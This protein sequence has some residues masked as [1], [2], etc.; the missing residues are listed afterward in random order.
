MKKINC[1]SCPIEVGDLEQ[2]SFVDLL[3]NHY[4]SVRKVIIVDENTHDFCLEYLLTAFPTLE[5]AEVILLP[6]GE[7]NKVMEVCF[8]VLEALS[9]YGIVRSDLIITLGGGVVSD[10]GGFIASIYKRG[11]DCIHIPTSLL[12]MVDAS[13]GGKTGIDLGNYKNQIGTFHHPVAVFID[14]RFLSTLPEEEWKSGFA[15]V[16]KHALVSDKEE[17][18]RLI[19][20]KQDELFSEENLALLLEKSVSIKSNV[21]T[22]DPTEKGKRKILNFGHTIGHAIEGYYLDLEP[23]SHGNCVALGIIAEAYLSNK[24]GTLSTEDLHGIVQVIRALYPCPED[25]LV[26]VSNIIELMKNDKKNDQQGI[27]MCFLDEIGSC[28]WNH[29]VDENDAKMALDYLY[30]AYYKN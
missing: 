4:S 9:E 3:H 5:E 14:Q 25:F 24:K 17:W 26:G 28:S 20:S 11:L 13:L 23:I 27:R 15:E 19:A 10:M 12:G 8:Q 29:L 16:L 2:S 22:E 7:E 1:N 30:Q 18:E 6:T 21:V